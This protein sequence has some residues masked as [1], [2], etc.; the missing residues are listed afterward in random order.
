M[1]P[2]AT[3]VL[4][5]TCGIALGAESSPPRPN[6]LFLVA[7]DLGWEDVGYHGSR[8]DTPHLDR[9]VKEGVELDRHYVYPMCT[10]T[11]VAL[12]TGKYPS[13]YGN[14]APA[15]PR[16]LPWKTETLA[17]ALQSVGYTTH[18][19]GK[20]HL[21]SRPEWAPNHF[22]FDE[23]YGSLAGGCGYF[24]HLYKPG[25]YS[26]TWHRDGKLGEEEGHTTDLIQNRVIDWIE[27]A[28]SKEAP[29]FIYVP[30][31][32]VHTPIQPKEEWVLY[33]ENRYKDRFKDRSERLY[34]ALTTHMDD[35]IGRILAA[36]ESTGQKS[37]TLV[38][39]VS[40]NGAIPS[41]K[42]HKGY[43][44]PREA[45]V[46]G[47]NAPLRGYKTDLYEGGIRTPAFA[48]WPGKLKSHKL[49]L[50]I[51]VTDW[52]PTLTKLAGYTPP[53][54]PLWDGQDVW[55]LLTG[56]VTEAAPRTMYWRFTR[57]RFA[58][59]HG[60]LKLVENGN[61]RELYDVTRDPT[62]TTDL[63]KTLP[64][65]ISDLVLADFGTRLREAR[66]QDF[67]ARPPDRHIVYKTWHGVD[68]RLHVYEPAG[69]APEAAGFTP[70]PAIVFFFGG[71]WKGGAPTQFY[72]QCA[73]YADR[74][75]LAIAAEYRVKNVHDTA[76]YDCVKDAKSAMRWVRHFAR[77][78]GVDPHRI[79]AGGGSAGGHV[80][81]A[82]ALLSG[83]N[84]VDEGTDVSARPDALVLFNPVLDNRPDGYGYERIKEHLEEFSPILNV[85]P[86][87][88]PTIIFLGTLDPLFTV[89]S[90]HE[91]QQLMETAGARC[92]L[93]L[94]EGAKHG[95]FNYR[96]GANPY[97][98]ET[99]AA[100]DAFL[101]SLGF[102]QP[103]TPNR[104][105]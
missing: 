57:G 73:H 80:A 66:Q 17:R 49:A 77:E 93:K 1:Q 78:L 42:A 65:Q 31:T 44:G 96:E 37:E 60:D 20:W 7:D 90:A 11:R 102:L 74:G 10:P 53:T 56:E 59:R 29:W 18:L 6:I 9:L 89:S 21:G 24:R 98:E 30:F 99:V 34:P 71:G 97:Y 72:P 95:F 52:M 70:R 45:A 68:L 82:T 75:M 104:D 62:E 51:H 105:G 54:E 94:Y 61:G 103:E 100:A 2:A 15:N 76:P 41:A 27:T 91:F 39:F 22:G 88:P 8:I 86:G 47:S 43:P 40:D 33:Y 4:F 19:A 28:A 26:V 83:F 36:V 3:V 38:V 101:E 14:R 12:L 13:R 5:L 92:D 16:V 50:P 87:A 67:E 23:S 35:A 32:A 46:C 55:P 79:A 63:I 85:R 48:F 69:H 64:E 81:A 25:N 84:E 58:L